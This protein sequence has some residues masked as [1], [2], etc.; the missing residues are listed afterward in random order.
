[1]NDTS[2]HTRISLSIN[3]F[4]AKK[5]PLNQRSLV[6]YRIGELSEG[7]SFE[8]AENNVKIFAAAVQS[9]SATASHQAFYIFRVVGGKKNRLAKYLP[10]NLTNVALSKCAAHVKTDLGAHVNTI[11]ILGDSLVQKFHSVLF[12]NHEARGPFEG[13]ANGAW[14]NRITRIFNDHP[15]VGMIGPT[16][17]CEIA[18]H[19]QSYAFAMRSESIVKVFAEF[20]PRSAAGKKNKE[21][22]LETAITTTALRLGYKIASLTS[23]RHWGETV[24]NG[25]C[26]NSSNPNTASLNPTSWCDF[27]PEEALFMRWGGE[28]LT[29]PDFYCLETMNHIYKATAQIAARDANLH[30]TLPEKLTSQPSASSFVPHLSLAEEYELERARDQAVRHMKEPQKVCFLVRTSTSV[31]RQ[32]TKKSLVESMNLDLFIASKLLSTLCAH[33]ILEIYE[34]L[35]RFLFVFVFVVHSTDASDEHQL[36]GLLLRNGR[37]AF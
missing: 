31:G 10:Y 18:P 3:N 15:S 5:V 34:C 32:A 37:P 20:N 26:R 4:D 27:R 33:I 8:V 12:L 6:I 7:D 28:P 13:R 22:V 11:H 19:V 1:M 35:S 16:I 21:E 25:K 23:E 2:L 14:W 9:H 17:S 24:F 30:L 29:V 36:G